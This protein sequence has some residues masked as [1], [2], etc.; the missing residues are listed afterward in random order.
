M[1]QIE[2]NKIELPNK[3]DQRKAKAPVFLMRCKRM[4][5]NRVIWSANCLLFNWVLTSRLSFGNDIP[6]LSDIVSDAL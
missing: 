1:N 2:D 6:K 4:E 5:R 3:S